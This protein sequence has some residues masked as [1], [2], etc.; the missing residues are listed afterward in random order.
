LAGLAFAAV[1]VFTLP[2]FAQTA[3]TDC[4]KLRQ[5][6]DEDMK[7][8][9]TVAMELVNKAMQAAKPSE[10]MDKLGVDL[11]QAKSADEAIRKGAVTALSPPAQNAILIY[12]MFANATMQEM[13][14]K[15]CKPE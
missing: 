10:M 1:C 9:H 15:G 12:L 6:Y 14:W 5:M 11:K 8:A 3:G 7:I 13:V 2:G 4:P